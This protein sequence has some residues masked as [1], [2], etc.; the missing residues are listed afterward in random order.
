MSDLPRLCPEL[1]DRMEAE[2]TV[3]AARQQPERSK[4]RSI[5]GYHLDAIDRRTV[6]VEVCDPRV[7][8][9]QAELWPSGDMAAF[10]AMFA[11]VGDGGLS[12][13]AATGGRS[14]KRRT[15]SCWRALRPP[16]TADGIRIGGFLP[17]LPAM[18]AASVA[19]P[20]S[21]TLAH[22]LSLW[23]AAGATAV[24]S[25][26]VRPTGNFLPPGRTSEAWWWS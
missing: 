17:R 19:Q 3:D 2:D 8:A 7:E 14:L 1:V 4:L 25:V 16:R 21:Q 5:A 20:R 11:P 12:F 23:R 13:P 24:V 26:E 10:A 9:W 22:P 6:I 18:T 15:G